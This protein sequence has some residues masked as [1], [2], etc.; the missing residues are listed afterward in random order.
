[1]VLLAMPG[2]AKSLDARRAAAEAGPSAVSADGTTVP[3]EWIGL[4]QR[5][6]P[7][8][9]LVINKKLDLPEVTVVPA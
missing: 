1:V 5:I 9:A 3:L 6:S 4:E 2:I 7:E 8:D